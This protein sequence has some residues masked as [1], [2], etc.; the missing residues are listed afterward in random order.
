[1]AAFFS[2]SCA[3]LQRIKRSKT[4]ALLAAAGAMALA[5]CN[6]Q[7]DEAATA[8]TSAANAAQVE[9]L[10]VQTLRQ[11]QDDGNIRLIDVR[12]DA[13]VADGMIPGA[14][15]IA[16]DSF[17]PAQLD[18]SDGREPVLYC[19]SDRRSGIAAERLSQYTGKPV[20]HLDGG[21]NAWRDEGLPVSTP[22]AN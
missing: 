22:A 14:E 7:A 2:T 18:L 13:E 10:D 5:G 17:D 4:A 8:E 16:L 3:N 11:L 12:T 9:T 6:V 20:R 15:H 1:M 21:I 19:R